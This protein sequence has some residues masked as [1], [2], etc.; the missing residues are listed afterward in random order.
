[1]PEVKKT[2]KCPVCN[3][4]VDIKTGIKSDYKGRGYYFCSEGDKKTFMAK[5][6]K[7]VTKAA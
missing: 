4:E 3:M 2:E 6:E 5:P 7:Y 1:M